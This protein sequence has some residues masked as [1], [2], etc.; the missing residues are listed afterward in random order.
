MNTRIGLTLLL[1]LAVLCGCGEKK[2]TAPMEELRVF[3]ASGL[4]PVLE[5]LSVPA[6]RELG[7]RIQSEPSGSQMACRKVSELGRECDIVMVADRALVKTL[8]ADRCSWRIDFAHDEVVLAVG[9]RAPDVSDAEEDWVQTLLKDN[10]R[11]GRVDENQGPI[12]YRALLVWKLKERLDS[13]GLCDKLVKKCDKVVD[14]VTRLTPL[15][16]TGE[17]DYAFVYRSICVA[18]DIRYIALDKRINLGD[19]ATDYSAASV[20]F[21]KLK[22]GEKEAVT[23]AGA[24]ITWSL[25]VPDRGANAEL[26][27]KFIVWMLVKE[28][29]TLAQ[30]GFIPMESPEFYGPKDAHAPFDKLIAYADEMK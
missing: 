3:H 1:T 7:I 12:G 26:A 29:V 28:C 9:A 24:P 4:T 10:V 22:A 23:V 25:T 11:L 2:D 14:H 21:D 20:S 30:H 17:I 18:R 6:M 8:L 13:P 27:R 5:T 16:K 15:L 19:G